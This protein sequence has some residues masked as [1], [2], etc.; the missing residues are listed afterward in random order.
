MRTSFGFVKN[1]STSGPLSVSLMLLDCSF[2]LRSF[3]LEL[4]SLNSIGSHL[5][6]LSSMT[7][8]SSSSIA[9]AFWNDFVLFLSRNISFLIRVCL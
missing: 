8:A 2:D 1:G 5:S 3:L 7:S 6:R 9:L 4:T